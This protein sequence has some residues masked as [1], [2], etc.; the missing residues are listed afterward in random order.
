MPACGP[1]PILTGNTNCVY[2]ASG[3]SCANAFPGWQCSELSSRFLYLAYRVEAGGPGDKLALNAQADS[4]GTLNYI[5]NGTVG[6]LPEP[7]DVVSESNSGDGH[8]YVITGVSPDATAGYATVS[9]IEQNSSVGGVRTERVK[10]WVLEDDYTG[11]TVEGWAQPVANPYALQLTAETSP[12]T[13]ALSWNSNLTNASYYTLTKESIS[14]MAGVPVTLDE[15]S[16]GSLGATCSYADTPSPSEVGQSYI[17]TVTA[18]NV[19][20][21][22]LANAYLQLTFCTPPP[23][24]LSDTSVTPTSITLAWSAAPIAPPDAVAYYNL[25]EDGILI[26]SPKASPYTVAGL[27]EDTTYTYSMTAVDDMGDVSSQSNTPA[28]AVNTYQLPYFTN[29]A[30]G[31]VEQSLVTGE[32][33]AP[34]S[35]TLQAQG[36]PTPTYSLVGAPSW[37]QIAPTTGVLS[38][39]PPANGSYTFVAQATNAAGSATTQQLEL[40]VPS[41]GGAAVLS[42]GGLSGYSVDGFGDITAFG[43]APSNIIATG[44]WPGWDI[45]RGIAVRSDG[46]SGYVLDGYGGIHPFAAGG[47]SMPP[48]VSLPTAPG[49]SGPGWPGWD[50]ARGIVLYTDDS[51]YV[52]DGFGGINQFGVNSSSYPPPASGTAYWS[53]WDIARSIALDP[54]HLGGQVM[55]GYGVLHP[56]SINGNAIA[57]LS[58]P[59]WSSQDWDIARGVTMVDDNG[60]YILDGLGGVHAFGDAPGPAYDNVSYHSGTDVASGISAA[61]CPGARSFCGA[62]Y[63]A[64]VGTQTFGAPM[65]SATTGSTTNVTASAATLNGAVSDNG[66]GAAGIGATSA[67]F[68]LSTSPS[69]AGQKPVTASLGSFTGSTN[70]TALV[71]GL[72]PGATYYFQVA[73]W[74]IVGT[75]VGSWI[76][77]TTVGAPSA[78]TGSA[79]SVTQ[80]TATLNGTVNDNGFGAVGGGSTNS[81]FNLNTSPTGSGETYELSSQGAFTGSAKETASITGLIPG[82]T[83]YFQVAAWNGAGTTAGLWIPFTTPPVSPPSATTESVANVTQTTVTLNGEVND[84]G[85]GTVGR[86]A[87]SSDFNLNKSPTGTGETYEWASQGAFTGSANETANVTGLTPNTTYYFQV[88]AW[89]GAGTTLGSWVPFT[90]PAVGAPWAT[91]GSATSV[92]AT[93][94]V[95]NG[96]VSDDGYG[97]AGRGATTSDF[98]IN[99]SPGGSGETYESASFPSFSGSASETASVT[100]LSPSTTYYFQVAAWNGAGTTFGSWI[101]FTTPAVSAP[102]AITA[103]AT[104]VTE[105]TATL[106]G[107]VNDN[108]C[109]AAGRG[110]TSSDFNLSTSPTGAGQTPEGASLGNFSGSAN[111]M[112]SVTGLTPNTT[113][114]F[115]VAG[116]NG[117]GTTLGSWIRFTTLSVPSATTATATSVTP[118]TATLNGVVN[119]NGFA[120]AGMGYTSSDFNL[121]TSPTGAGYAAEPASPG[122]FIGSASET[123]SVTGL[124]PDTTYYFQVAGWNSSGT[125]FGAWIPFTTS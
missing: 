84:N 73:A 102:S 74:N 39:T 16:E 21:T 86:G 114:Y 36:S 54:D 111:E 67:D 18:F 49:S 78:T 7:G 48:P 90:T 89:N 30:P 41:G 10:D 35:T 83:Y 28:L 94:A 40:Y 119:D 92:T 31:S 97:V 75:T 65:P 43:G 33:G 123:A 37:L 107:A 80:T 79:T 2:P 34:Y 82:T 87:T 69:G 3:G 100:G 15:C 91:T 76:P 106:N 50:I 99:T 125:A 124:A 118:T 93:G 32:V 55:D 72:T 62:V 63:A 45:V 23:E 113:Y 109:G 122:A 61:P 4:N 98:N 95:L 25:Y 6:D 17:Y 8:T 101:P 27:Q 53:G 120:A 66:L 12:S 108:G 11:F 44:S 56:F 105:T 117:V 5:T 19:G 60:G 58:G 77:F 70:E 96:T 22:V 71:T 51:G 24:D 46:C 38:G 85:Y 68:N 112:A 121:S 20:G 88:A 1:E 116:W 47:C 14:G 29:P 57:T 104:N 115:Q 13:I 52:L 81:D 103:S 64:G 9:I 42:S 59:T 26:A 110:S